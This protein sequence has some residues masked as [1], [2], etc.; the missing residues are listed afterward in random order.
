[1]AMNRNIYN[2]MVELA[3]EEDALER[4]V[5]YLS[6]H[7]G[8]FLRKGERVFICF[9]EYEH[10]NLTWLMEQA[11]LR[12]EAVPVIWGPERLWKTLLQQAFLN[13]VT[14]IIGSP[15][16]LLGLSKL[17]RQSGTPLSIR[18]VITAGYPAPEWMIDGIVDGLDCEMG[19]CFT[20]DISGVVAGFACGRSWGVHI[21]EE[22]YRV[23]IVD[24]N[25]VRVPD[26]Q[27]GEIVLYPKDRPDLRWPLGEGGRLEIEPCVCGSDKVRMM[28][29]VWGWDQ[30]PAVLE[31]AQMLH[32]WTSVLDCQVIKGE[33]G[34]ELE[35][36]CFQGEKLPKLPSVAKLVVRPWNP[37]TDA[38]YNF[39]RAMKF[40]V[41]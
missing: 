1:M 20:L 18:R 14:A 17:R 25:D 12:C 35:I 27:M 13:K 19:G 29:M 33:S 23:D 40:D 38:P 37:Q 26:G 36:V 28:D 21:R 8:H 10:G 15:L 32:S 30:D 16:L 34:L 24:E 2:K 22:E 9:S 3:R 41:K 39:A 31:L 11:V 5:A 7:L 4:S 6:E